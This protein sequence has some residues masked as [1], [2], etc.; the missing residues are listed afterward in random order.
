MAPIPKLI[1][2]IP[3]TLI[4]LS[5]VGCRR[6]AE[7]ESNMIDWVPEGVQNPDAPR[8]VTRFPAEWQQADQ[9][10]NDFINKVLD[11]CHRGDYDMFCQLLAISESPPRQDNF[12]R[13]WHGVGQIDVRSVRPDGSQESKYYVHAVA[14]LRKPDAENRTERNLVLEVFKEMDQWRIA[15]ASKEVS[16]KILM[17][18]SQPAPDPAGAE[19]GQDK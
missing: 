10:L 7:E 8:P 4:A 13:I 16:Q 17:A 6:T 9:S 18:D 2:I 11:V 5:A 15:G 19:P 12:K 3:A 14:K 1:I